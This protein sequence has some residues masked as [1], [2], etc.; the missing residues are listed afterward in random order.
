[1]IPLWRHFD[2]L[3]VLVQDDKEED[4]EPDDKDK[5]DSDDVV[6]DLFRQKANKDD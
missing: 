5:S 6:E 1:M 4:L 3:P 2:P